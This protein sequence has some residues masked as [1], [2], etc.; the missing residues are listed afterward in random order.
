MSREDIFALPTVRVTLSA[1][2]IYQIGPVAGQIATTIKLLSGGTLEIGG[3]SMTV[4]ISGAPGTTLRA[5]AGSLAG[6]QTF[7][8]MYPISANEVFSANSSGAIY[9]YASGATCVVAV[10]LGRSAGFE[11]L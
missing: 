11:Q 5:G 4:A 3:Y 6:G 7:G 8:N 1:G 9:L 2:A 10:G